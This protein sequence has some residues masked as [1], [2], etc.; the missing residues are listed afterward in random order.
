MRETNEMAA[1]AAH[2]KDLDLALVVCQRITEHKLFIGESVRGHES[3]DAPKVITTEYPT[4]CRGC[5]GAIDSGETVLWQRG[6]GAWH[7][8]CRRD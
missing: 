7:V 5:W 6:V 2:N 8:A 4:I 1:S 3:P